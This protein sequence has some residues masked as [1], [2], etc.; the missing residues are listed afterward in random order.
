MLCDAKDKTELIFMAGNSR[1]SS[2]NK[3]DALHKASWRSLKIIVVE[4]RLFG[5]S[6]LS[7]SNRMA[8]I[9]RE[10]A[11]RLFC[12]IQRKNVATKTFMFTFRKWQSLKSRKTK[13]HLLLKGFPNYDRS[14]WP[15]NSSALCHCVLIIMLSWLINTLITISSGKERF[16]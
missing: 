10:M 16:N 6:R 4:R 14:L 15:P 1:H 5:E 2:S 8:S 3:W 13:L 12:L 11:L 7:R 9:V